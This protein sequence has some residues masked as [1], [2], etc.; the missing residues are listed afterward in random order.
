MNFA[1][2]MTQV[3]L[4]V[5]YGMMGFREV[6]QTEELR[7]QMAWAKEESAGSLRFVGIS[8]LLGVSYMILPR[9]T[10]ILP[11][12]APLAARASGLPIVGVDALAFL[13]AFHPKVHLADA[14]SITVDSFPGETFS[15]EVVYISDQAEFAPRNVQTV[16]GRRMTVYAV[17][18]RVPNPDLKLKPGMPADVNFSLSK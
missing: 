9:L 10:G 7:E 14:V 5:I 8:E 13:P 17:K 3:L 1:L 2:W 15:G 16:E 12:L 4:A 6:F 11:W 18:L